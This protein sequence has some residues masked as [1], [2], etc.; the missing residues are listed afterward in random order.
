MAL[1]TSGTTAEPKRIELSH[2]VL[3]T[4][5]EAIAAALGFREDDSLFG[6]APLSH[7]FGMTACMNAAIAAG[8][9]L[10]LLERFDANAALDLI[11]RERVTVFMGVPGCW[12]RS[13]PR[14]M[15]PAARR[16]CG[17][18]TRA[19]RSSRATG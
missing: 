10:A 1:H 15:R 2:E 18:R 11:E 13:L 9:C 12:Q 6:S 16:A 19:P 14:R 4:N 5:A 17:S 7:V 8:A 3:R